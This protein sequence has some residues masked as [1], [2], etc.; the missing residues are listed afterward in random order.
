MEEQ[1]RLAYLAGLFDGE[2]TVTMCTRANNLMF[3]YPVLSMSSTSLNLLELYVTTFGGHISTHKVYKAHHKQ[4]YSWKIANDKALTAISKLLPYIQEPEKKR[5][6]LL[7]TERYK[8]LTVRNGK[9]SEAQT[10]A[11]HAFEIDFFH[12]SDVVPSFV[13]LGVDTL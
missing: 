6:M 5:R 2:G 8:G 9:Y 1:L 12:P 7:L 10:K 13:D 3:R 11:K 4:S